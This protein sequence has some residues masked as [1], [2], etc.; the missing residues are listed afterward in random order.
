MLD[1]FYDD[2][3]TFVSFVYENIH[4]VPDTPYNTY[5]SVFKYQVKQRHFKTF[6]EAKEYSISLG[7]RKDWIEYAYNCI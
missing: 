5:W 4:R 6:K 2:G 1:N 3:L 7:E